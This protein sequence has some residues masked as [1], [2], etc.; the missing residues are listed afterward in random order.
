[1]NV[2]CK[3][4]LIFATT[5]S[6]TMEEKRNPQIDEEQGMDMCFAPKWGMFSARYIVEIHAYLRELVDIAGRI[7][8]TSQ[9]GWQLEPALRIVFERVFQ[10]AQTFLPAVEMVDIEH[11]EIVHANHSRT[12][13]RQRMPISFGSLLKL[14][15]ALEQNAFVRPCFGEIGIDLDGFVKEAGRIFVPFFDH[16]SGAAIDQTA[17]LFAQRNKCQTASFPDF[18]IIL[19]VFH[20]GFERIQSRFW[21]V[22]GEERKSKRN[23]N[24]GIIFVLVKC[25]G[26]GFDSLLKLF[27][28][29]EDVGFFS[30]RI[31]IG[32]LE[33]EGLFDVFERILKA[34]VV[35]RNDGAFTPELG[36]FGRSFQAVLDARIRFI[37]A[38]ERRH[39]LGRFNPRADVFGID[40]ENLGIER[41]RFFVLLFVYKNS[42]F[43]VERKNVVGIF[44]Q[45]FVE[46]DE[47]FVGLLQFVQRNGIFDLVTGTMECVNAG[48]EYPA[49]KRRG[50]EFALMKRKHNLPLGSMEGLEFMTYEIHLDPGDCIFVYT[51]GVP[52][53]ANEQS[54]QFGTDR[55]IGVLNENKYSSQQDLLKS[56]KAGVDSFVGITEQ[57]DDMTMIGFR[58]NGMKSL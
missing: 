19:V 44:L 24:F 54:E 57:F 4:I 34:I 38:A 26:I 6:E 3:I 7:N 9:F 17:R 29:G 39:Q 1:M 37:I 22:I 30:Q 42:R 40:I 5:N 47:T 52:E 20:H 46:H 32:R 11:A 12:I 55:M 23:L 31:E 13:E 49:I 2:V 45:D 41:Q 33:R 43:V 58:Y 25:E 48:H 56:V 51:D 53:A 35:A 10:P 50:G 27:E 18:R 16:G 21:L 15:F 36:I 8:G 28:C 14:A